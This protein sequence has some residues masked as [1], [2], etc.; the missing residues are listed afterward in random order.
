L[1]EEDA[2]A[3][4]RVEKQHAQRSLEP[5]VCHRFRALRAG[6]VTMPAIT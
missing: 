3:G 6:I 5:G 2:L 1:I 4:H